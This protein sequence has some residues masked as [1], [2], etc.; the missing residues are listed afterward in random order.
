[1]KSY[2]KSDILTLSPYNIILTVPTSSEYIVLKH[3]YILYV[4]EHSLWYLL[5]LE[6]MIIYP[7]FFSISWFTR[8][9]YSKQIKVQF[10]GTYLLSLTLDDIGNFAKQSIIMVQGQI[11]IT[12]RKFNKIALSNYIFFNTLH[13]LCKEYI[14]TAKPESEIH[15]GVIWFFSSA[16]QTRKWKMEDCTCVRQKISSASIL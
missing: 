13:P 14:G 2:D 4:Y 16:Q 6:I 5:H 9:S 7:L 10:F 12:R 1:M 15:L 3:C 11:E 8:S